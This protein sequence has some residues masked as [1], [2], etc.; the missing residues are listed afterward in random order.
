MASFI[1]WWPSG[2]FVAKK[3]VVDGHAVHVPHF[4]EPDELGYATERFRVQPTRLEPGGVRRRDLGGSVRVAEERVY[5][6]RQLGNKAVDRGTHEGNEGLTVWPL[7]QPFDECERQPSDTERIDKCKRRGDL[8]SLRIEFVKKPSENLFEL[9]LEDVRLEVR[10]K[11]KFWNL[12]VPEPTR[13][14]TFP[15]D[16]HKGQLRVSEGREMLESGVERD[17]RRTFFSLRI[18]SWPRKTVEVD[19][20]PVVFSEDW[21]PSLQ[22]PTQDRVFRE[23]VRGCLPHRRVGCGHLV[24]PQVF[25]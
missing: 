11:S 21:E 23:C 25:A 19:E 15:F 1:F 10:R 5:L 8:Q 20:A 24:P 3:E 18:A 6:I 22:I 16:E 14:I 17:D 9:P 2:W 4:E 13:S 7:E 12:H